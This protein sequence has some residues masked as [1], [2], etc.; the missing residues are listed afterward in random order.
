MHQELTGAM[1]PLSLTL[2][3]PGVLLA[4]DCVDVGRNL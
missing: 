2:Q 1:L 3:G 4:C